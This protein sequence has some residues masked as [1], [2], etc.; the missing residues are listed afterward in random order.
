MVVSIF[1]NRQ[2]G[3]LM[4]LDQAKPPRLY[5]AESCRL[6]SIVCCR[7]NRLVEQTKPL[8]LRGCR[9]MLSVICCRKP[10]S[11]KFLKRTKPLRLSGCWFMLPVT[12]RRKIGS[13]MFLKQEK[14]LRLSGGGSCCLSSIVGKPACQADEATEIVWGGILLSVIC[15]RQI[16]VCVLCLSSGL[17]LRS[18]STSPRP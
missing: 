14:P 5:G 10:S 2:A 12:C 16:V 18:P 15:H 13:F 11:F 8:R 3:S 7:Q 6:S 1:C 17:L 4:F 9:F